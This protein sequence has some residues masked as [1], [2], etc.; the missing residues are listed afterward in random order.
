MVRRVDG[1]DG[2]VDA[3]GFLVIIIFGRGSVVSWRCRDSDRMSRGPR[4]IMQQPVS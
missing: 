2:D 4:T 3:A 1:G